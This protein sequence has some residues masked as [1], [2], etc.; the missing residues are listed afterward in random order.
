MFIN[1][2]NSVS[3][4]GFKGYNHVK[5]NVGE[6]V[7]RFNYPYNYKDEDC[8]IQFFRA[9]PNEKYNY[10]IDEK[11]IYTAAL[12]PEGVDI[13]LQDVT[14]LDKDE[15][16]AY[17]IVRKSKKDGS[18][19]WEG[20]DTGTKV[21]RLDGN[22][23]GFRL[24][25]DVYWKDKEV[26]PDNKVIPG[27][28]TLAG[29][30]VSDYKYSLV[31][32]KGT[33][34]TVQGA[35]Y[36]AIP[37]SFY[38]GWKYRG[39]D[40]ENTGEI[41]YD[42]AYQKEM[43][44]VKRN[45]SNK[46]GGGLAG[47]QAGIPYLKKNGYKV[48]FTTPTA[49]G[50]NKSSHSY[51]NKNNFW[52]SPEMGNIENYK[53]LL[54]EYYKNGMS[55]VYDGT[56]TSEGL[57][58]IHFAYAMRWGAQNP[59]TYYWFRMSGLK[60][61]NLTLGTVPKNKENLRHKLINAPFRYEL[62][63]NGTYKAVPKKYDPNKETLIQIYDASQV[64]EEQIKAEDKLIKYD[65][66]KSANELDKVTHDDTL[67]NY[68]YEINPKD[69]Q[70]RIDA[71]NNL[72]KKQ[73]KDIKLDS[74]EGT[75]IASQFPF[76][77]H[78]KKTEGGFVAWDAN[79][80]MAKLNYHISGYDE[81]ILQAIPDLAQRE[82]E[83][84]M[85]IRGT[86]EVQDLTLQ[87]IKYLIQTDKDVQTMY[88]AQTVGG[89]KTIDA[90]NKLIEEGKLPEETRINSY[91][92][93]NILNGQY[94]LSPKGVMS[95]DDVTVKA[96]MKLPLDAL[97]VGENTVGVLSTSYFSNRATTDE[98]IG[99]SRFDLMKDN[100]PHLVEPYE[101]TYK[102]VN[103]LFKNEIKDFADA[104]IKKV[105]ETSNEKLLD[106]NGDY[107]EYGEYVIDL[108]GQDITKYAFLKSLAG[109]NLRTKLL[110]TGEVTYDYDKLRETT[111]LKAL[112]INAHSP[113][114]EAQMLEKKIEK[115]MKNL[116]DSDV[117]YLA[118]SVS[119]RI[120]GTDTASF[121]IAEA[122]FDKAGLGLKMRLDAAKDVMDMDSIRNEDG[123]FDDIMNDFINFWAKATNEIKKI[124][125]NSSLI[126]EITDIHD[127][128]LDKYGEDSCPYNGETN[129][130]SKFNGV[131]D[132]MTKL[133]NESGITTE[134]GYSYFFTN[135]LHSFARDFDTAGLEATGYN[136]YDYLRHDTF[137]DKMDLLLET[138]NPDFLRNLYTFMGNH[139]KPR[140]IHCLA[141][142]MAMFHNA[143]SPEEKRRHRLEAL[144]ILS[145][146]KSIN[147]MPVEF[148]LNADN[149]D[150]ARTINLKA[151]AKSKLLKQ[152]VNEDLKGT[153]SEEDIKNLNQAIIDL[154]NGN[155]L[156]DNQNINYQ[157]INIKELSSL[158]AAFS[159]I[160][161]MAEKH[162]LKL[163]AE[164]RNSLI[165]QVVDN[166]NKKDLSNYQVHGDFDW[167]SLSEAD[168]NAN[169]QY[170]KEL[171]GYRDNYNKYSLYTVQLA[172]LLNDSYTGNNP[173]I[174][175]AFTDFVEKYNKAAVD[176]H[177]TELPK[178][179]DNKITKYKRGYAAMDIKATAEMLVK[180]AEY[181]TGK[182]MA[183]RETIIDT[184]Y[185]AATEPAEAKAAMIME[186]LSALFGTPQMFAGDEL[187]MTGYEEKAKN[188]YLQNRN[189]L[190]W[191]ETE[192]DNLIGGYRRAIMQSMNGAMSNRNN[193][194]LHALNDGT[195]YSMDIKVNGMD[196]NQVRQ[197]IID[198]TAELKN[199]DI[200]NR[201]ELEE[202]RRKL[203]KDLAKV[204]Y[205]MQSG[206]GDTT[207]SVFYVGDIEH[208]NK[209]DYF[210]KYN[211]LDKDGNIDEKRR[212]EFFEKNH[213]ETINP[214]NRYIPI[215]ERTEIDSITCPIAAG[216]AAVALP[217]GAVFMNA[218][219]KD[220]A[221][222][223]VNKLGEIVREDGK[224]IVLDGLTTR[225]GVMV[226]RKLKNI[227][228]KGKILNKQY[229][230]GV[231]KTYQKPEITENGN[232][233]SVI[234]K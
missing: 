91:M 122:L 175:S 125:S 210:A 43:E 156:T 186:Y 19:I 63:E 195:P 128:M 182:P 44:G 8:E 66:L 3:N 106:K 67:I 65:N 223:V 51:W 162:G 117:S 72:N 33:T 17:K 57:E 109:N 2:I 118:D 55:Y 123:D 28:Y 224:K 180:Q 80:D 140:M 136:G 42:A 172:R 173:A 200:A 60:N 21:I 185:K 165:K 144:S 148:R 103:S 143:G 231:S 88:T 98:T 222:Y 150:Y 204:A 229:N 232:N 110:K 29:P 26:T 151:A 176:A 145:G 214:Q 115:G 202:E 178:Y 40:D 18:I 45:F 48:I 154:T 99:V 86:K 36:L 199:P 54:K 192:G 9:T 73:G 213:I 121:R 179:E 84:E 7:M 217:V 168:K 187:G 169:L 85:I 56:F 146:A 11:P 201:A 135:L 20:A 124:D 193:E 183:N 68:V 64:S 220:K 126:A 155:Y 167:T 177:R 61:S 159:T 170:G 166:A 87:A 22:E 152:V 10:I 215:Q 205:M 81:K 138:R 141:L 14:N 120:A 171:L 62:Q 174:K 149:M 77:K 49:N 108:I 137:K 41:Y 47:L 75:L 37:D 209:V 221:K 194:D 191:T 76:F 234:A 89:A 39:F 5:N 23:Y 6:T 82:H 161:D 113:E 184:I 102:N 197:R 31:T 16:F 105:N 226:L 15:A 147:D 53:N 132:F 203:T 12:K 79:T 153:A 111:S 230:I 190:P 114:D 198:I 13:N 83:R 107:T 97:E 212:K 158:E 50:D 127:L 24:H 157:T 196:R 119:K 225:N 206:N 74:A 216:A 32:R 96:L 93:N 130:N 90:L 133:F 139:D 34:P 164:E 70:K 218:N 95:K 58:G 71:I 46:F 116:S 69:Y 38:P 207:V 181:K 94:I 59:Q 129:I 219:T 131:P 4:V 30:A 101:R 211:L 25:Q 160:L 208:E 188:I 228:F 104:V 52:V 112:G 27:H 142:D 189:A 1:K 134:A 78:G 100:N 163:S 227:A 35:A 92:L 233:L